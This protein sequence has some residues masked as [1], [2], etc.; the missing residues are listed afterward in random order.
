VLNPIL[1]QLRFIHKLG[2]HPVD[3]ALMGCWFTEKYPPEYKTPKTGF[4][5]NSK[6]QNWLLKLF[7]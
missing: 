5:I 3:G 7:Y 4:H 1:T 2:I 6:C